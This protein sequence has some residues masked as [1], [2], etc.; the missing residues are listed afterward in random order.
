MA[1]GTSCLP[2]STNAYDT[3][4]WERSAAECLIDFHWLERYLVTR[5]GRAKPTAIEPSSVEW[6]DNP[7]EPVEPCKEAL[8]VEERLL[9]DLERLCTL[10]DKSGDSSLADA[11]QSKFLRKEANVKDLVDCDGY[12]H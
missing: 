2:A 1:Y 9:E 12:D 10:V 11:I 3:S 8:I 7:V 4:L 6:P 5:G